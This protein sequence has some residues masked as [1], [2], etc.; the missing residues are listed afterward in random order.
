[1]THISFEPLANPCPHCGQYMDEI[2]IQYSYKKCPKCNYQE[3][4]AAIEFAGV[5]AIGV[6]L[7]FAFFKLLKST[8]HSVR[9]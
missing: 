2:K 1:M 3:K 4:K 8:N 9:I 6:I 5:I 7:S